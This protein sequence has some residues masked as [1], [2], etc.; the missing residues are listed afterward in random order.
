MV[1]LRRLGAL[2]DVEKGCKTLQH[3]SRTTIT[4]RNEGWIPPPSRPK[5]N[6]S[7]FLVRSGRAGAGPE[8]AIAL[9]VQQVHKCSGSATL[10]LNTTAVS[11][12]LLCWSSSPHR[13]V[14]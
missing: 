5:E 2:Q 11:L 3:A 10:H 8:I 6:P 1:E 12:V 13:R 14:R 9:T 7:A 4:S